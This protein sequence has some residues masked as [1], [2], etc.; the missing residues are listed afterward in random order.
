VD[1]VYLGKLNCPLK[2]TD[3]ARV[4]VMWETKQKR[5]TAK[6]NV[7]QRNETK[8]DET[9]QNMYTEK[10]SEA[11]YVNWG[12][13]RNETNLRPFKLYVR[14]YLRNFTLQS[15]MYFTLT[16]FGKSRVHSQNKNKH[17]PIPYK[18]IINQFNCI[19]I[20]GHIK[21]LIWHCKL[22]KYSIWVH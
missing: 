19:M 17:C 16:S 1:F 5:N 22:T 12:T 4:P 2:V 9:K 14:V 8:H 15:K 6:R 21:I 18:C 13:K 10:R 3:N 11:D 7:T 20:D